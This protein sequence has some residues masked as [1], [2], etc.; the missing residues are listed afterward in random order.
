MLFPGIYPKESV[1]LY[2]IISKM[3]QDIADKHVGAIVTFVGVS[4][5]SSTVTEKKVES[6][7]IEAYKQEAD[8]VIQKICDQIKHKFSLSYITIIHL[9]GEFSP[10]EPIVGVI[11]ASKSRES[12]FQAMREAIE[13][14]K[15]EPPIFK[16]ENYVDGSSKWIS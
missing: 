8:K 12:A 3:Q 14:Y 15:K 2:E 16:K 11:V 9:E 6:V 4:K 1:H 13:R 7:S 10:C 5:E